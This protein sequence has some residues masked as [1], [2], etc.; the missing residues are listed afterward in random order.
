MIFSLILYNLRYRNQN[1]TIEKCFIKLFMKNIQKFTILNSIL[2][3]EFI[4]QVKTLFKSV[5]SPKKDFRFNSIQSHKKDFRF[6][7]N[8]AGAVQLISFT[9]IPNKKKIHIPLLPFAYVNCFSPSNILLH[10]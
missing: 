2:L 1:L 10:K 7:S 8:F 6:N 5:Q 9:C 4:G 3:T